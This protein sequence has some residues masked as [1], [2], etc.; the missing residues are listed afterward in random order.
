MSFDLYFAGAYNKDIENIIVDRN[1]NKL[2]SN[3]NDRKQIIHYIDLKKSG[4]FKGKLF[5]DSG[6]FSTHTKGK[7][8]DIDEYIEFINKNHEYIDLFVQVDHI[9][10]KFGVPRTIE[11]IM[12]S[13]KKSWENYLYMR[14]KVIDKD[15]LLPVFHQDE[16]FKWLENMLNTTFDGKYIPYI[17]ISSSKD[18]SANARFDWYKKVYSIIQSSNN[19]NVKVH[20]LGTSSTNHCEY[21]PFTSSDAT[22]WIMSAAM[23]NITTKYGDICI[24]DRS[25]YKKNN[26]VNQVSFDLFKKYIEDNGFTIE[27]LSKDHNKRVEW[28]LKYLGEWSKNSE[29]KGPKSFITN[30]LF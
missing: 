12:E 30:K 16:D 25:L 26:I 27:E 1:Y 19:P 15:K 4:K 8:V 18:K 20:S 10:G 11:Q 22:S 5:I 23:G 17:C 3:I 24:S 14:E 6:A 7:E 9:P 28:N 29:Y 2:L 21:F 13:P